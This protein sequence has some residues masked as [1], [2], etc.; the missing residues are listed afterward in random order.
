MPV[1]ITPLVFVPCSPNRSQA[2]SRTSMGWYTVCFF[3]EGQ[4][5]AENSVDGHIGWY[6]SRAD[7][8]LACGACD[9]DANRKWLRNHP[10]M[11]PWLRT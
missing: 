6:H 2:P 7:A 3:S 10:P 9:V 1:K 11:G 8:I 5:S 4:W